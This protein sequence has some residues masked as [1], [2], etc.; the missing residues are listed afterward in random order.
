MIG[1]AL[2]RARGLGYWERMSDVQTWALVGAVFVSGY[3]I[4]RAV[5][6]GL[7]ELKNVFEKQFYNPDGSHRK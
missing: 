4:A 1:S 5:E 3:M 6:Q 7:K 2:D